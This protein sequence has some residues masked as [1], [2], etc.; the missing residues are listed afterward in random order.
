M[1]L[2]GFYVLCFFFFLVFFILLSVGGEGRVHSFIS[3][4][5]PSGERRYWLMQF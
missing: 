3:V 2:R 1:E 5:L 4:V